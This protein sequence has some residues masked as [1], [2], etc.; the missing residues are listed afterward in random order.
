LRYCSSIDLDK[1][2]Q[3]AHRPWIGPLN[4]AIVVFPPARKDWIKNF[5]DRIIPKDYQDVLLATNG[6]FLYGFS[7]FGLTPSKQENP[8]RQDRSVLQCLDLGVANRE[9]MREYEVNQEL[10][11][12]GSR[13]YSQ[14]ENI[15]YFMEGSKEIQA[16]R[17]TGEII[18]GW[19]SISE[20]LHDEIREAENL[21]KEQIE[22]GW[23]C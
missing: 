10:F 17:K 1:T 8:P 23:W 3:I 16:V 5:K 11:H 9:W 19:G 6:V 7:L 15:G 18:Q 20:F 21:G 13:E 22:E 2:I 14:S 4:Y 12:F